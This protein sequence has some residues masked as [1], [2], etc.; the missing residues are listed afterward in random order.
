MLT[1][2]ELHRN[3]VSADGVF[4]IMRIPSASTV[5]YTCEDDWKDNEKGKSC[6]PNGVYQLK[7]T[8]Y[9]KH[10]IETFEV[11]NVPGRSRI[12]VHPGNTEEDVEGCILVGTRR[13]TIRVAR[14]EDTGEKDKVKRAVVNSRAAFAQ[15][16]GSLSAVDSAQLIITW[17]PGLP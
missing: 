11:M 14:D 8:V 7:R 4:G 10:S 16:M 12:L 6:I 1:V 3:D 13:G 9:H 17:G 15:F 2:I 5:L